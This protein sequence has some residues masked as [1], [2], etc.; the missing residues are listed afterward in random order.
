MLFVLVICKSVHDKLTDLLETELA[1]VAAVS[2]GRRAVSA[3]EIS[4]KASVAGPPPAWSYTCLSNS[5][6]VLVLPLP[7]SPLQ[8]KNTST[9]S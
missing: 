5:I 8:S 4:L 7:L 3:E 9:R 1:D 2:R 6:D